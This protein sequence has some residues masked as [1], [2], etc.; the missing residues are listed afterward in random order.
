MICCGGV[1]LIMVQQVVI[2]GARTNSCDEG[3][4]K[5]YVHSLSY[6]SHVLIW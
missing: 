4:L 3:T 6:M 2:S 1:C 5:L